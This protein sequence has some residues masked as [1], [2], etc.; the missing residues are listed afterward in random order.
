MTAQSQ[1]ADAVGVHSSA[2]KRY[3]GKVAKI[4][5]ALKKGNAA[6]YEAIQLLRG[7]INDIVLT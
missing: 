5:D 6:A 4:R 3:W 1:E 2:S 7:L